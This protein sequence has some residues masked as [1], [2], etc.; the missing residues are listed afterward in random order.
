MLEKIIKVA[1]NH[2]WL[3]M[4]LTMALIAIGIWS[5][6]QIPIDVIDQL[7]GIVPGS[8][9]D[10]IRSHRQQARDNAQAS[11]EALFAPRM[12][13]SGDQPSV[14]PRGRSSSRCECTLT[15]RAVFS[16]RAR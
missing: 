6:R 15:R 4:T 1:I 11:Y 14:M 8:A 5:A 9:L 2:R 12:S 13:T 10:R 3:V 16:A 7:V